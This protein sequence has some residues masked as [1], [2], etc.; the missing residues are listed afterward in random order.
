[1]HGRQRQDEA[2]ARRSGSPR[3]DNEPTNA[4]AALQR[5]AGNAAMSSLFEDAGPLVRDTLASPGRPLDAAV[6]AEMEARLGHD[7]GDVRIHTDAQAHESA[8]AISAHAYTSGSHIAFQRSAYNP[9]SQEGRRTIAHELTHVVQQQVGGQ[10][11]AFSVNGRSLSDT[12]DPLEQEADRTAASLASSPAGKAREPALPTNRPVPETTRTAVVRR[13]FTGRADL[14]SVKQV[15][16]N[17]AQVNVQG[18]EPF[19]ID[20]LDRLVDDLFETEEAV[21]T[22]TEF[23]TSTAIDLALAPAST[24]PGYGAI[25]QVVGVA[26]KATV[27]VGAEF[28]RASLEAQKAELERLAQRALVG[29]GDTLSASYEAFIDRYMR[30]HLWQSFASEEDLNHHVAALYEEV[31][32]RWPELTLDNY[33]DI[34]RLSLLVMKAA[35]EAKAASVRERIR[36]D[37]YERMRMSLGVEPYDRPAGIPTQEE[38]TRVDQSLRRETGYDGP[39]VRLEDL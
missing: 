21:V 6:R 34:R 22:W 3:R 4:V 36:E 9:S 19:L 31:E 28:Y 15:A 12:A 7:F 27:H 37:H 10:E 11:D 33:E 13:Y 23:L 35:L 18:W 5:S 8:T 20:Q 2:A 14:P 17:T 1:M 26:L 29:Y 32:L 39:P 30:A 24:I 25:A 38:C 16:M